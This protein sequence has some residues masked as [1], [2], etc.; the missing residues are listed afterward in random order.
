MSLCLSVTGESDFEQREKTPNK[1]SKYRQGTAC[2]KA[3]L[4]LWNS[5]SFGVAGA[6]GVNR[7]VVSSQENEARS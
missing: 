6:Q 1:H 5:E 7:G 3:G 4:H 2:A